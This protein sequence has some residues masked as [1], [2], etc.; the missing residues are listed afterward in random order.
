[1]VQQLSMPPAPLREKVATIAPGVEQVVLRALAKD[2]KERF[3]SVQDFATALEEAN[4]ETSSGQ[5]QRALSSAYVIGYRSPQRI[6]PAQ[7]TPLIGREQEV[8]AA[9]A[10]LRRPEVRLVT[11][12]GTGGIGKTRLALQLATEFIDDFTDGVSF[13]SLASI[14]DPDLVLSTI[15][16]GFGLKEPTD[17]SWLDLLQVFFRHKCSLVVLDN[18]EHVVIAAPSLATLLQ[19]CPRLKVLVT[20]RTLLHISGEHHFPVA[21]LSVPNLKHLPDHTFL[22]Q[23]AAVALFVQRAQ[24]LR[25]EFRLTEANARAVAEL[26]VRLDGLPLAIELAAARIPL[27]SPQAL[28]SRLNQRLHGVNQRRAGCSRP[29]ADAAQ[30]HCVEL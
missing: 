19:A 3:A 12:T 17:Q 5:T 9:C 14:S 25:P 28:L 24:A 2:P 10:L 22:T 29:P 15:A 18:F 6:L 20:S 26:C 13:V 30:H 16:Q 21:P 23:Y 27:L 8:T 11:L 7:L 4:R 1:M